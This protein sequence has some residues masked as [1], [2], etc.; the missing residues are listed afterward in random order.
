MQ[1]FQ[2]E[3]TAQKRQ[4]KDS[5]ITALKN[6]EPKRW[7][8]CIPANLGT[9]GQLWFQGLQKEYADRVVIQLSKPASVRIVLETR[10]PVELFFHRFTPPPLEKTAR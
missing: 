3:H 10:A 7:I 8:L 6:F 4:I 5:L 9:S 2:W 1:V